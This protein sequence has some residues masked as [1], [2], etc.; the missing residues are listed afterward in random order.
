MCAGLIFLHYLFILARGKT[1][2]APTDP[3]IREII[4]LRQM[5]FKCTRLTFCPLSCRLDDLLF[6][7]YFFPSLSSPTLLKRTERMED[8]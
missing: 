4:A 3:P 6:F 8:G 2:R 1:L 7:F 5:N